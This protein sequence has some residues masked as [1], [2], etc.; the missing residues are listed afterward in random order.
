MSV[1]QRVNEIVETLLKINFLDQNGSI[2]AW[3]SNLCK[4]ASEELNK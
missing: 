2:P 3:S 4:L 1:K